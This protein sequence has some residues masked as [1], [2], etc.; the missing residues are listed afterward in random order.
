MEFGFTSVV[1]VASASA[2]IVGGCNWRLQQM[3]RQ[4]PTGEARTEHVADVILLEA[5]RQPDSSG[6][7]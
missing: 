4:R 5:K 2:E 3:A 7:T 1:C 6:K